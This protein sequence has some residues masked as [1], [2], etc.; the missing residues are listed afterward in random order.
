MTT[1][2]TPDG[3]PPVVV[4]EHI[5]ARIVSGGQT[6]VD[7]AAW[8]AARALGIPTGGW[9]PKGR[10]AEDG[11]IPAR[12]PAREAPSA[13]YPE[14][15]RLNVRDSDATLILAR[16]PLSGGTA[17]TL[18]I[19]EGLGRPC[20]VADP[21]GDPVLVRDWLATVRPQVLNVAGP[22]ESTVPGTAAQARV[23][24]ERVLSSRAGSA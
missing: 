12:Y 3:L 17:L 23:F 16:R 4:P 20:L 7:R 19:A 13:A 22:R 9:V 5:P 6:G 15:T 10:R 11:W 14:R 1:G 8:D 24:L 18:E 2:G 21:A